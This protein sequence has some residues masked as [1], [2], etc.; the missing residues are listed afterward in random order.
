MEKIETHQLYWINEKTGGKF[1][2]GV[3]FY[4]EKYD[5]YRLKI[6]YFPESQLYLKTVGLHANQ[7]DYRAEIVH[8]RQSKF[9]GRRPVGTGYLNRETKNEIHI[10]LG[11]FSNKLI[12]EL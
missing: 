8:T 12:L 10:E 5:E 11:P 2:A 7:I 9:I 6:D 4:L 3:A 1:A